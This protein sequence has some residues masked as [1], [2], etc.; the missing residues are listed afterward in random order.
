MAIENRGPELQA[1]CYTLLVTAIIST[2]LRCYVR[3]RLVKNFGFD[4]WCMLAA[5]TSFTLFVAFAL[6]GVHY[7]TGRHRAD[8]DPEDFK[9]AM[10]AW[11][12]CYIWYCISMIMSKISI[13]YLILRITVRTLDTFIIYGTM[14]VTLLAGLTFFFVTLF[15]CRPISFFWNHDQEGSCV[16]VDVIMALTYLYSVFSLISDFTCA[17]LPM[18]LVWSLNMD[19][20][21]K[22]ALIP[23]LAM[24][25]VASSA[26]AV[27][28][29]YVKDFKNP[30]FL[31]STIDIAIW[32]TTEQGLAVTAGSLATLRPLL[33]LI[34]HKLGISSTGPSELHGS[35]HPTG[36]RFEIQSNSR[37]GIG[38][39]QQGS[40]SLTTFTDEDREAHG[41]GSDVEGYRRGEIDKL[42]IEKN[43]KWHSRE[44]GSNESQE[45]LT[46]PGYEGPLSRSGIQITTTI[47]ME[48]NRI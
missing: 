5:L 28:F 34:N 14:L 13:G 24:A 19:R 42:P 48:E 21:S 43:V 8:L 3:T 17:I 40:F 7:G 39:R 15:Q 20:R 1:V 31:W 26:V 30:D 32:S 12:F 16:S 29:A 10:K 4:D 38:H 41:A 46:T 25:C 37:L 36:S 2:L 35:D 33:R 18:F 23:I 11:W 44:P 9:S 22:I 47:R 6:V 45:E 27:R